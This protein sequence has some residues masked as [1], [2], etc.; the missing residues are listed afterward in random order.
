MP[1]ISTLRA[2]L[3]AY[4]V[5]WRGAVAWTIWRHIPRGK[6][7]RSPSTSAPASRRS[8]SASASPRNSTPTSSRIVSALC[9]MSA[10]PSSPRTSNGASVRVRNGTCSAWAASRSAWRAARPPLAPS[11][12]CRPSGVLPACRSR[13]RRAASSLV[14]GV[15]RRRRPPSAGARSGSATTAAQVRERGGLVREGHRLHEVLLEA[16]LDRGLDLLDP[17]DDALDLASGPRPTAGR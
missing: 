12:R 3:R 5:N 4:W 15:R 14:A 2:G 6:R 13:P 7:T 16:R 11:L 1:P 17:P 10:R 8:R 9:S